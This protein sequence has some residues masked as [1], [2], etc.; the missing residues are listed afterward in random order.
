MI[1]PLAILANCRRVIAPEARA[2][3][4]DPLDLPSN[5]LFDLQ[6]LVTWNGGRVRSTAELTA[7]LATA[8]F[9]VER[10]IPTQS[11]HRIAEA[12]PA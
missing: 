1:G 11:E 8:G 9:A 7:L 2:L 12:R 10:I 4:I 6:M 5:E 3:I